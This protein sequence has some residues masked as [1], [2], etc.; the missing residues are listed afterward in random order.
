MYKLLRIGKNLLALTIIIPLMTLTSFGIYMEYVQTKEDVSKMLKE[1]LIEDKLGL[2]DNY[3]K[4]LIRDFGKNIE[5][6]LASHEELCETY[7]NQLRLIVGKE[8]KYLYLLHKDKKGN[9]RF[10]LDATVDKNEKAEFNQRFQPQT[11]IWEKANVTGLV[12]I[13]HQEELDNLWVSVAYPVM[14]DGKA[15]AILGA[16]FTY[17]VYTNILNTLNPVEILYKYVSIF[18]IFMLFLAYIL[19]Y[20]YYKTRKKGFI[21]PLTKVYNRQ[22]LNEFL[23]VSS[24]KDYHI[25]MIDLDYFKQVNDRYGHDAGDEVL[26]IVTQKINNLIRKEDVLIRF[27][28]EEFLL[29]IYKQALVDSVEIA[30]RIR[31][32]VMR[33]TIHMKDNKINITISIGINPYPYRAKNIE[34]AIKISDEQLYIAKSSGRNRV[35]VFKDDNNLYCPMSKRISDVQEAIDE[36]RIKCA[37]Q[38]IHSASDINKVQKYELL[39]RLID[40]NAKVIGP[41]E[42][43]P[44]IRNTQVYVNLSRIVVEKA[45]EVLKMNDFSLSINFDI[46]DILNEDLMNLFKEKFSNEPNL[47]KRLTIEILE[48]EEIT[49]FEAIKE[50]LDTLKSMGLS[51]ALDDFGSGYANFSYLINLEIDILKIDGSIVKNIKKDTSAYYMLKAIVEFSKSMEIYTV[52]EQIEKQEELDVV[53]SLGVDYVQGYFLERPKFLFD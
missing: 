15:I 4:L 46:Q 31:K 20:L 37:F 22:Y 25:M 39:I 2:F 32:T 49:N 47:A 41:N 23:E 3:S 12:Q 21:D 6:T 53:Q 16:D 5:N 28:G 10:L 45:L 44:S 30:N 7:E 27:G 18:M 13:V 9:F 33:H 52:V 38:S 35:E 50:S 42:F 11:D 48:H 29:L 24:M 14:L 51:I 36:K 1:H 34:E 43:L 40:R 17:D 8:I 26:R 19:F